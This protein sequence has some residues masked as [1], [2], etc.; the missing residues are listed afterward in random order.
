MEPAIFPA[1]NELRLIGADGV[2]VRR[3]Q[4]GLADFVSRPQAREEIGTAGQ[5][6]LKFHLQPGAR[7]GGGEKIRNALFPGERMRLAGVPRRS[8]GRRNEGGID[9]GQRDEFGQEFFRARHA[10]AA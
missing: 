4:N 1:G 2:E 8:S 10:A 7:G 3:E 5:D 6:F 9:A